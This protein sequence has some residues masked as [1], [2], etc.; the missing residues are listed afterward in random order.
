MDFFSRM[1]AAWAERRTLLCVGLD[2]RPIAPGND[3]AKAVSEILAFNRRL[4]DATAEYAACYKPNIAFYE[5]WGS[6]GWDA[7][8]A[9]I[10][11]I[12]NGIPVLLDAKR[13]DIDSTARAYARAAF[14]ELGA[15]A[16]TL[17]PYLGRDAADPFLE[18]PEAGLFLLCRTSNPRAGV[19]QDLIV[20][21][22]SDRSAFIPGSCRTAGTAETSAEPL[23]LRVARE[24][25]SWSDRVGLV[26]AGNDVR[27]L[28]AV[29]AAV[30][31]AWFLAPGIGA[32]G[33]D[34]AAAWEAGAREDGLG[35]IPAVSRVLAEAPDP[36]AA[37]AALC[38]SAVEAWE[39]I[40][41]TRKKEGRMRKAA[42]PGKSTRDKA[43]AAGKARVS[44]AKGTGGGS[45]AEREALKER[46]LRGFVETGCF[47]TGDFVLK[48]GIRSPFYI[49]LRAVVSDI[50]LL[51][52]AAEAYA[53][54]VR[55]LD[56]DR[57]GGIPAAALPLATA[58]ALRLRKPLVWPRM[59]V[60]DH[61][62]GNRV[63][64]RFLPGERVLLL[65]DLITSGASKLEAAEILRGEGL[66]VDD[67]AVLI[68]R[69]V[70]GRTEMKAAGIRLHA[71]L[72][73]R[74][75]IALCVSLGLVGEEKG[76]EMEAFAASE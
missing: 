10:D 54:L 57:L 9:T 37:A 47:K 6:A 24:C 65:D 60:K 19:F 38:R 43:P 26:V 64:G 8:K 16:V 63:E 52:A 4:I 67:L 76:R 7:L 50:K 1:S 69:G 25:V 53:F 70:R 11:Q 30:P 27:A 39:R 58:A 36:G 59:P 21:G 20:G 32:Q 22:V 5:A 13:G 72:H 62:T 33:G 51:E 68:E 35:V 15:D 28:E 75:L 41:E 45:E 29:R 55:D 66:K 74:D 40:L 14:R 18:Y 49:D 61:G 71:F 23:Y 42:A 34:I 17:N 73:V 31:E 3:A 12:P 48:S 2:P 56:Y 44:G 46:L